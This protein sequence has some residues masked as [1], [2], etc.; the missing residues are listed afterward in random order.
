MVL[1]VFWILNFSSVAQ[2]LNSLF[3]H[4]YLPYSN[5]AINR[6]L[7]CPNVD[8][9]RPRSHFLVSVLSESQFFPFVHS[10]AIKMRY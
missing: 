5:L 10:R 1:T 2:F 7:D 3:K 4:I 8:F 6:Q 9:V